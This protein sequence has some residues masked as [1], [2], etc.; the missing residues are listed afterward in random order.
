MPP[1]LYRAV[2]ERL[3]SINQ[4]SLQYAEYGWEN[5]QGGR[6][7][8]LVFLAQ[9]SSDAFLRTYLEVDPGLPERLTDFTSFVNAVPEPDVLARLHRAH[10]LSERVRLNAVKRIA[11]LAV[12]TPDA[13]WLHVPAWQVLL[14]PAERIS[15]LDTVRTELVPRLGTYEDP[16]PGERADQDDPFEAA[17]IE[18]RK[19]FTDAGDL[20]AAAAFDEAIEAFR[21]QPIG[22]QEDYEPGAGYNSGSF[23]GYGSALAPRP[24]AGR[25]VFDDIDR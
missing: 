14:K 24:T 17:L 15:L 16:L 2:A 18:Y 6:R 7:S 8:V 20:R 25:S 12:E 1:A 22:S 13:G 11:G 19:A 5:S 10:L 23:A 3:S 9:R 21:E 4:H